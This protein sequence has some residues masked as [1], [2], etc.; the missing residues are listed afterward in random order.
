MASG[1]K[2]GD[3]PATTFR[4][5]ALEADLAY[6]SARLELL[7]VPAT[8]HQLAQ[9]KAY[10]SMQR[11]LQEMLAQLSQAVKQKTDL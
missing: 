2:R 1:D 4:V 10:Q 9:R 11:S 6:F 5:S 7:G 8:L 3:Y